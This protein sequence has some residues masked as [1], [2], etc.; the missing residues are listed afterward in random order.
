MTHA[1]AAA[2]P[3]AHAASDGFGTGGYRAYVLGALLVVYIFNFIDRTIV[4]ILTEPPA[5][6]FMPW[7]G[8]SPIVFQNRLAG[9]SPGLPRARWAASY[10]FAPASGRFA[11]HPVDLMLISP[12]PD[13]CVADEDCQAALPKPA[14]T[15]AMIAAARREGRERLAIIVHDRC[16]TA[17]ARQLLAA[18]RAATR[19]GMVLDVLGLEQ[20]L[21]MLM[22]RQAAWDA[23][24]VLPELRA[25][26]FAMLA[27]TSGIAGP[28]PML[29]HG[30]G[31]ACVT[32]E[33]LEG[34]GPAMP[35]DA[36]LLVQALALTAEHAGL[37]L[38]AR[39]LLEG[40]SGLRDGGIET[41]GRATGSPYA[42]VVEEPIL[43]ELV[44]NDMAPGCRVRPHWKALAS[45]I[46][47]PSAK[48]RPPARLTLVASS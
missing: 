42:K 16:R 6:V 18:D 5:P 13:A 48:P 10:L 21:P 8:I 30:E 45:T 1:Q 22:R 41:A 37:G 28:W 7:H 31:L 2:A 15:R 4:N 26:V 24:I 19:E 35:L 23:I 25:A 44:C 12:H 27:E 40:W 38:A 9:R 39:Q 34:S 3:V 11:P 14:V 17:M 43:I 47:A 29:W 32:G 33:A 36:T 20:A 46:T